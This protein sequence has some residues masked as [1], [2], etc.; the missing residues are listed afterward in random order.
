MPEIRFQRRNGSNFT[1]GEAAKP[2]P[3]L[4]N[5]HGRMSRGLILGHENKF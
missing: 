4:A 1:L 3:Q 2:S 5:R